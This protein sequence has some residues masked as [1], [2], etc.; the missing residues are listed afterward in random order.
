MAA[1]SGFRGAQTVTLALVGALHLL[2]AVNNI[3]DYETNFR[4]VSHVMSMDTTLPGNALGWRAITNPWMHHVGYWGIIAWELG[5]GVL[6]LRAASMLL[7]STTGDT[8]GNRAETASIQALTCSLALWLGGFLLVGGEWF[9]M[10]QSRDWN[11]QNAAFRMAAINML[12]LLLF[13][14]N[15][16][17]T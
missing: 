9:A 11:G 4:F 12:A 14:P 7:A 8:R 16:S 17:Q 15:R 1:F 3:L 10:W 2:V 13:M 6:C 5:A